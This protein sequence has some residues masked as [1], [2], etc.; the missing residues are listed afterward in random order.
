LGATVERLYNTDQL[1][2]PASE[3]FFSNDVRASGPDAFVLA[4]VA[5]RC[6]FTSNVWCTAKSVGLRPNVAPKASVFDRRFGTA[7]M[8][9]RSQLQWPIPVP[10]APHLWANGSAFPPHD[11]VV[12]EEARIKLRL[13]ARRWV[14]ARAQVV[15]NNAVPGAIPTTVEIVM[16]RGAVEVLNT[17]QLLEAKHGATRM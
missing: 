1:V 9:N 15:G 14:A 7:T 4:H 2:P 16:P 5:G 10:D 3:H 8:Y 12:L 11:Q 13:N 17:E 6:G